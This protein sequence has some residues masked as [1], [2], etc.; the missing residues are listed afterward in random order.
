MGNLGRL[1]D[2]RDMILGETFLS[3]TIQGSHLGLYH[4]PPDPSPLLFANLLLTVLASVARFT[5][6]AAVP[7]SS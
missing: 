5:G 3:N 1:L 7:T 6:R 4:M 2:G